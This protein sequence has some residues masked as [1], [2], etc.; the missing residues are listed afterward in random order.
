VFSK[1]LV[2]LDVSNSDGL[3]LFNPSWMFFRSE[4]VA[5]GVRVVDRI[6][7]A[8]GII[9]FRQI[10]FVSQGSI[11][12]VSEEG[13]TWTIG[14]LAPGTGASMRFRAEAVDEGVDVN[15]VALTADQSLG[16]VVLEEPTTVA[17]PNTPAI[18]LSLSNEDGFLDEAGTF[19]SANDSLFQVGDDLAYE[20]QLINQSEVIA[21]G[22]KVIEELTPTF[23]ILDFQAIRFISQGVVTQAGPG[24][25][26]WEVGNLPPNT[27]ATLR[28]TA[29]AVR[30][31]FDVTRATFQ[32]QGLI[33]VRDEEAII[34]AR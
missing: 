16:T 14:T 21:T 24:G 8:T 4:T 9:R 1:A 29:T 12:G 20:V 11:A 17:G 33:A 28:F 7:V 26:T 27:G 19:Q 30:E 25:F 5:T 15:Q 34:V 13:F 6:T 3:G 18:A 2:A 23:I 32:A 31:G 22:V 10:L